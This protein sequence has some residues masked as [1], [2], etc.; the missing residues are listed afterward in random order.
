M[1]SD[2]EPTKPGRQYHKAYVPVMLV[3]PDQPDFIRLAPTPRAL[4]EMER[5]GFKHVKWARIGALLIKIRGQL[6]LNYNELA[7]LL[8]QRGA[9][10]IT[11]SQIRVYETEGR[12]PRGV[13]IQDLK[14]LAQAIG[15]PVSA[16]ILTNGPGRRVPAPVVTSPEV[17]ALTAAGV[18]VVRGFYGANTPVVIVLVA[19]TPT[20]AEVMFV[21][22]L[23]ARLTASQIRI[24][25]TTRLR[26]TAKYL[27]ESFKGAPTP[28]ESPTPDDE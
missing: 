8:H 7:G 14:E 28:T 24:E 6:G 2:K 4:R 3:H 26:S 9:K 11:P 23:Q 5:T 12:P 27:F 15:I 13:S 18:Y 17:A 10:N 20:E 1:V 19:H 21:S 16:L 22:R 25:S